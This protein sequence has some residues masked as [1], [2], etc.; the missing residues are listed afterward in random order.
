[1]LTVAIA[2]PPFTYTTCFFIFCNLIIHENFISN[3]SCALYIY[4]R[5]SLFGWLVSIF[6]WFQSVYLHPYNTLC[7][8]TT[9]HNIYTYVAHLKLPFLLYWNLAMIMC[10]ELYCCEVENWK[11]KATMAINYGLTLFVLAPTLSFNW[12][13]V[14]AFSKSKLCKLLLKL[15]IHELLFRLPFYVFICLFF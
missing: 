5:A 11:L 6:D 9:R 15:F 3:S 2:R 4:V 8:D 14:Q 12:T 1:M 7:H 10:F 13:I